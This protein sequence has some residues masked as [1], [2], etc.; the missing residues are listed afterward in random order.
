MSKTFKTLIAVLSFGV[1]AYAIV[2]YAALPI[3][4]VLHPDIRVT[5]AAHGVAIVYLHVFGAALALLLGPFQFWRRLRAS[6][7]QLHRWTGR[8]YLAVGV[9]VGG[10][11]GLL[12]AV[13]AYGGM[14]SR[15]G[16]AAL[17]LL[18]L[19][20]GVMALTSIRRGDVPAH[21]RWMMRNYALTLAAVLLRLYLPAAIVAGVDLALAYPLVAWLCWAPNLLLAEWLV[22]RSAEAGARQSGSGFA[23]AWRA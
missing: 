20:T 12:L 17:A 14:W 11:T 18:W 2:A 9:G 13:N 4:A 16:F 7:P 23:L 1:A 22:R 3:G 8:V 21:R 5:F 6:R 10:V 19:A 15:S